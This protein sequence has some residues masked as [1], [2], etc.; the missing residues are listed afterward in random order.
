MTKHVSQKVM[1]DELVQILDALAFGSASQ[2]KMTKREIPKLWNSD[3]KEFQK[4]ALVALKYIEKFDELPSVKNQAA[5]ISGLDL[6]FLVLADD[7]FETLK[8]FVLKAIQS[9]D[10]HVREAARKTSHWLD[11]SLSSRIVPFKF[12]ASEELSVPEKSAREKAMKQYKEYVTDIEFLI[13]TYYKE[14]ECAE[15]IEDMKPSVHKS[16]EMLR[17]DVTERECFYF[18]SVVSET[19]AVRRK[20]VETAIWGLLES[21]KSEFSIHDVRR[22]IYEEDST[23]VMSDIIAMFDTG[24]G[25]VELQDIV[26]VVT[27]AWNIFPHKTLQGRSPEQM[28]RDVDR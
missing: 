9:P 16:L 27:D 7:H 18:G 25:T 24:E 17:S 2:F 15:Y 28:L 10:G 3:R 6:F 5:L 20:E 11:I 1:K 13:H 4:Q 22:A 21:V 26:E 8:D 19:D 14:Q 23:E 12:S